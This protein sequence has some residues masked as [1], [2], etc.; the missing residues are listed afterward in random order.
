M[1]QDKGPPKSI[2]RKVNYVPDSFYFVLI[3]VIFGYFMSDLLA[4]VLVIA[5]V[6]FL[7]VILH[8]TNCE[9]LTPS[10]SYCHNHNRVIQD[11][12]HTLV[13]L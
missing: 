10:P 5:S 13:T 4:K 6:N 3:D 2:L 8:L 7:L 11:T 9:I 1:L 12:L